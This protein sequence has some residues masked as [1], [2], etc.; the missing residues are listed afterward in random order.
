MNYNYFINHAMTFIV[1]N[2][3]SP[4]LSSWEINSRLFHYK[5]LTLRL[6]IYWLTVPSYYIQRVSLFLSSFFM[7]FSHFVNFV[8]VSVNSSYFFGGWIFNAYLGSYVEYIKLITW[9]HKRLLTS[10][11][12]TVL[13]VSCLQL[14]NPFTR[15]QMNWSINFELILFFFGGQCRW[16]FLMCGNIFDRDLWDRFCKTIGSKIHWKMKIILNFFSKPTWS[17]QF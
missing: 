17:F 7:S 11:L 4:F 9:E 14:Y 5:L 3:L 13:H 15:W 10:Y 12:M 16:P 6:I 8:S 2:F 1:I